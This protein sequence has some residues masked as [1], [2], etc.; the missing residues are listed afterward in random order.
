MGELSNNRTIAKNAF[1][2]YVRMLLSTVVSLYT[3][4]V[5][6]DVLGVSDYGIYNIVGGVVVL[7]NFLNASMS[8]ATSRFLTFEIGKGVKERIDNV[9]GNAISIHLLLSLIVAVLLETV[10]LWLLNTKLVIPA[11]RMFAAQVVYQ[12]SVLSTLFG[13]TQVPY[14]AAIIAHEKMNIYAYA[15][16][17]GVFLKLLIVYLLCI[18]NFDKLIL[19]GVLMLAVSVSMML[20]YR[21]Y[22]WKHF[23][24]CRRGPSIDKDTFKPMLSYAAW[25]LYGD[26]CYSLRQQGTNILL[27]MFF[28][29]VVNAANGIASSVMGV[30][31]SFTQNV[32]TAFRPQIIKS[33]AVGNLQRMERL[34]VYATKYS[35]LLMGLMTIVLSCEM[36]FILNLWL[37]E[38]PPY[39]PWICRIILCSFCVVSC[40]FVAT[41]G[42]QASGS[43]K[44][45]SFVGGSI[46]LFGILPA[47]YV[48]L[49]MGYSPYSAYACYCF[50]TGIMYLCTL[51]ILKKQIPGIHL[52]GIVLRGIA[53]IVC[54]LAVTGFAAFVTVACL[55]DG[56]VRFMCVCV[57]SLL[58][59]AAMMYLFA[60]NKEEKAVVARVLKSLRRRLSK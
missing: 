38:V 27:N 36:D 58:L 60:M 55:S 4:R 12:L 13:I 20:F 29:T 15:E 33:Y 17:A 40:S 3:S 44:L 49:K 35:L 31:L 24:E 2:L 56:F 46:S 8:G 5:V 30:V 7:F 1:F 43:V 51:W 39:T 19:Y 28:G 45:Q 42:I 21:Y 6:L 37:K 59:T 16:L 54:L 53:P 11:D 32:L 18:G 14:N 57:V 9:F 50:F 34:M 52:S 22:G 47:T 26:G 41:V 25:G 48:V 23:E 10:G